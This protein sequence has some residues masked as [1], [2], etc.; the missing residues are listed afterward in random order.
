M[1]DNRLKNLPYLGS[2][3]QKIYMFPRHKYR[4]IF[5]MIKNKCRA[6]F[7]CDIHMVYCKSF[8]ILSASGLSA[9]FFFILAQGLQK[10]HFNWPNLLYIRIRPFWVS[11]SKSLGKNKKKWADN[12]KAVRILYQLQKTHDNRFKTSDVGG[13]MPWSA[14][15][16]H[17]W[18]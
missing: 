12:T 10:T 16:Q 5:F 4:L 14:K 2:S 1:H 15:V 3:P 9:Y 6:E 18:Q 8:R 17:C 13:V 7:R 11:F